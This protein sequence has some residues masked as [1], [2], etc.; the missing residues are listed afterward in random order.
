[1]E[2]I[3]ENAQYIMID[4]GDAKILVDVADISA[5]QLLGEAR[6]KDEKPV[7]VYSV[8]FTDGMV[9]Q[10]V[11]DKE[12]VDRYEKLKRENNEGRNKK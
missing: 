7:K 12:T 3:N 4:R 1:M 2:C 8:Q 11:L 5:L 6:D 10:C 9:W